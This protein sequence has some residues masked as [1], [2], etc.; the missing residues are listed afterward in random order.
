MFKFCP[1]CGSDLK[2]DFEFC[3]YCG[4]Q[5]SK[6]SKPLKEEVTNA[7]QE[8]LGIIVCENCGEENS[9]GNNSCSYCGIKLKGGTLKQK[10]HGEGRSPAKEK[11]AHLRQ[12]NKQS[13]TFKSTKQPI[14]NVPAKQLELKNIFI[15]GGGIIGVGLIILLFSGVFEKADSGLDN[16]ATNIGQDQSSIGQEQS[17]GVDL[18]SIPRINELEAKVKANPSDTETLLQL[19]HLRNDSRF[20]EEAIINYKEYLDK[21]PGNADARVDMG[22]CYYNLAKYDDA[23]REMEKALEYKP[24]HQIAHLNLGIV[25]LAAGNLEESKKWFKKTVEL[26]PNSEI[27]KKAQELLQSH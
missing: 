10:S 23:K 27:G 22:V 4:Y 26:D 11:Q 13:K 21:V 12:S 18:S 16:P 8:T 6:I 20:Y 15:I 9:V 24:D 17:S 25:N 5:L 19:A 7:G 2:E 1:R 3:P 14:P